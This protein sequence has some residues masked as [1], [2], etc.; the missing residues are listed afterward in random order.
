MLEHSARDFAEEL[1]NQ[2]IHTFTKDALTFLKTARGEC[3]SS[4]TPLV[5]ELADESVRAKSSGKV[6]LTCLRT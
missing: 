5:E 6:T 3:Q 2:G 1:I 4:S